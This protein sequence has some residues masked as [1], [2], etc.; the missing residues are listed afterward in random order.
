MA[1]SDFPSALGDR[2]RA[3]SELGRLAFLGK[4]RWYAKES[5]PP[6]LRNRPSRLIAKEDKVRAARDWSNALFPLNS[7]L[8]S[9]PVQYGTMDEFSALLPPGA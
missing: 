6:D 9:P 5:Y 4:I 7:V 1:L 3:A 2:E 8:V